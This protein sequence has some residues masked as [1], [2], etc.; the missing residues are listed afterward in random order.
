[1]LPP[2]FAA[3]LLFDRF[4]FGARYGL[5]K[6]QQCLGSSHIGKTL[7]AVFCRQFQLVTICHQLTS[8]FIATNAP[9]LRT[10]ESRFFITDLRKPLTLP[11]R[12][13]QRCSR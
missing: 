4:R 12:H 7:L 9:L 5:D 6:P 10:Q 13:A 8:F 11:L 1:M 2:V 3:F